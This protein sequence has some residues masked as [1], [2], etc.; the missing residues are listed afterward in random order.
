MRGI[1]FVG[2]G[3]AVVTDELQVRDPKPHEVVVRMVNAGVCHSD[4]SVL[5][6]TIPFPT[7][8]AMGHEGAG[9][10]EEVGSAVTTVALGDHVVL[11]TLANCGRCS[12]CAQGLPTRCRSSIGN[13]T[14]PFTYQGDPCFNFAATSCFSER[15]VV[16]AD[17]KSVV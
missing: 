15:T 8:C 12:A 16:D 1:V 14:R 5:D 3:Q 6:G 4:L 13:M 17:R 9:V 11:S 2:D 7:P 10:V